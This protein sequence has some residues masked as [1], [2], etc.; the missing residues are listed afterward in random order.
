MNGAESV[1]QSRDSW[2]ADVLANGGCEVR[3]LEGEGH[4]LMASPL[5]MGDVLTEIAGYWSAQ[6]KGRMTAV[7]R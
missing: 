5:I 2:R 4:G 6:E 1:P 3:I 7:R